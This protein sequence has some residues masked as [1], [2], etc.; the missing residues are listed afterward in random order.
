M[1]GD[2]ELDAWRRQWQARDQVPQDLRQRVER[3]IR[4]A[5]Y[6]YVVPVAITVLFGGGTLAWAVVS[7]RF[8]D[9][10]LAAGTWVFI[11]VTWVTSLVLSRRLG[12]GAAPAAITT[13]AFLEYMLAICRGRRAAIVT[14][15]VL[16]PIFFVFMVVWRYQTLPLASIGDFLVSGPVLFFLGVTVVLALV[17]RLVYRRLGTELDG[18]R[19]M[20][21]QFEER[22]DSPEG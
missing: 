2:P 15:A 16:Y 9:Y 22:G 3:E 18:L 10:V 19:T 8:A 14:A 4:A 17:G 5:R 12:A 13:T 6:E 7:A 11:V 1:T 21:R 20:R